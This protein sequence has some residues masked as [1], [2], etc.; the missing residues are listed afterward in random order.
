MQ[1]TSP[2]AANEHVAAAMRTAHQH[3]AQAQKSVATG[4]V[5]AALDAARASLAAA[6]TA[7][8]GVEELVTTRTNMLDGAARR[9]GVHAVRDLTD[10]VS[11]LSRGSASSP[12][13][14]QALFDAEVSTRLGSEAAARSLRDARVRIPD[15]QP[16][17]GSSGEPGGG[18]VG[19]GVEGLDELGNPQRG[20]GGWAGPDGERY[21]DL[22]GAVDEGGFAGPDGEIY[23][24]I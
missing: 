16:S 1:I 24:G 22:G 10:A 18:A 8:R 13:L 20:G 17:G 3:A 9:Y 4:A 7:R 14:E 5:P 23:T 12:L 2:R 19:Y 6:E 11:L 15:S 21:D